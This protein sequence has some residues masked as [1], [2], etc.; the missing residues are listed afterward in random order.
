MAGNSAIVYTNNK[1]F[2]VGVTCWEDN[3]ASY[4]IWTLKPEISE[5]RKRFALMYLE[6]L[7]FNTDFLIE[8][9]YDNCFE[10]ERKTEL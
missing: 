4:G 6:D 3:Q 7:G 1:D 10:T 5:E 9:P 2:M 8:T